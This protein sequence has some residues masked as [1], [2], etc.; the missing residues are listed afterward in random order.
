MDK[1]ECQKNT[2]CLNK[3]FEQKFLLKYITAII[4]NDNK[5]KILYKDF[6]FNLDQKKNFAFKLHAI[7][8]PDESKKD[9]FL[10]IFDKDNR[11]DRQSYCL[12]LKLI[13]M[14]K[15]DKYYYFKKSKVENINR[16]ICG[17][18]KNKLVTTID[19][20]YL[21]KL[22]TK[23]NKIFKVEKSM[24]DDDS[25]LDLCDVT[26]KIKLIKLISEGKTWYEKAGGFRLTDENIYKNTEIAAKESYQ[27]YYDIMKNIKMS[28]FDGDMIRHDEKKLDKA[29]DIIKKHGL[30]MKDSIR[31]II[32]KIFN[33]KVVDNCEKAIIYESVLDLPVRN[34]AF[35]DADKKYDAYRAYV[36]LNKQ[37][38]GFTESAVTY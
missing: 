21:V 4:D 32:L 9:I 25:K 37:I 35:K 17:I 29:V 34:K 6:G 28:M 13:N 3:S 8:N 19:G 7:Y 16:G 14:Y 26:M 2:Y 38:F 31:K 18:K 12:R 30:S 22:V 20:T 24:L 1:K 27:Y 23:I 11:K 36:N 5:N 10:Y 15:K 33:S